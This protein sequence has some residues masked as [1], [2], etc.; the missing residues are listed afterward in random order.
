MFFNGSSTVYKSSGLEGMIGKKE[1]LL[2]RLSTLV[3]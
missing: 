2:Y 3:M 1:M